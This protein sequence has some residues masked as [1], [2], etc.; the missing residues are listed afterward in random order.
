MNSPLNSPNLNTEG[1]IVVKD[2]EELTRMSREFVLAAP[3][4]NRD[5]LENAHKCVALAYLSFEF[6]KDITGQM[7]RNVSGP[8]VMNLMTRVRLAREVVLDREEAQSV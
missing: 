8:I 5:E 4:M 6:P 7:H 2:W 3:T 1:S